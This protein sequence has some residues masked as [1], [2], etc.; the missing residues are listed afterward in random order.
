MRRPFR[1]LLLAMVA[2]LAVTDAGAATG[3]GGG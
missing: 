1:G 3:G 2:V